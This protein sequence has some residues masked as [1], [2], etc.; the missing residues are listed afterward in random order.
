MMANGAYFG[1]GFADH[2]AERGI[3]VYILDWRGHGASVPPDP[4]RERW[5]FDDYVRADLPAAIDAVCAD[6]GVR[7]GE[8]A[9]LGH[10]LGGL[11]GLAGFGTGAAPTPGKI[12]LF[13]TSVWLPG[14]AGSRL[15]RWIMRAYRYA[16]RPMGY[17]PIRRARI[18]SDDE[19][20]GY[21]DQL[22]GW[23]DTGRWT[24]RD[25]IDYM[26]A[27]GAV[28][29][30]AWGISGDGDRLSSAA[31][32]QVLLDRLP[33]A[34]PLRRVGT[35]RGDAVNPDHFTLFTDARLAPLWNELAAWVIDDRA[36]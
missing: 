25:G 33:G 6:A 21:V 27:L 36:R 1:R 31:D 29:A 18:G 11:V 2:L 16:A 15:R 5:S 4:H 26:A 13:A 7:I 14:S 3:D 23:A 24:S 35:A 9:Y 19:N 8:L 30:P 22:T 34:L 12:A 20:R 32:C 10:S 17:A 28:H